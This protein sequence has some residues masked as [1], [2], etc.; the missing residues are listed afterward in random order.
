MRRREFIKFISGAAAYWPL[1]ARAQQ[2]E[3]I[4]RIGSLT[5]IADDPIMQPRLAA[6]LQALRQLGWTDGDNV[7]V[8]YRWGGGDADRIRC[9]HRQIG[10]FLASKDAV[11]VA[12]N[13]SE[14]KLVLPSAGWLWAIFVKRNSGILLKAGLAAGAEHPKNNGDKGGNEKQK[15]Y[16]HPHYR[17]L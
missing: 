6:F 2:R 7:R 4:R 3:R 16:R 13:V 8:D 11:D 17:L 10:W 1:V 12:V 14:R 15:K 5:G 9:L